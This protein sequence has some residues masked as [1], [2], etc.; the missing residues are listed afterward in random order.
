MKTKELREKETGHLLH[1]LGEQQ[2]QLFT[3]RT[4]SVTEKLEDPTQL[5]KARREIARLKTILRQRDIEAVKKAAEAKAA[6][7]KAK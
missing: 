5:R 4:Q 7:A 3:L 6:E 2:K 1:E